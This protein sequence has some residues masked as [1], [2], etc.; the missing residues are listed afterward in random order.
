MVT[1]AQLGP[2]KFGILLAYLSLSESDMTLHSNAT[3]L[4]LSSI[5]GIQKLQCRAEYQVSE[6]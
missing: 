1:S 5:S 3:K 6:L 4:S 2:S